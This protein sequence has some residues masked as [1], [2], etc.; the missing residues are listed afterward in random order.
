MNGMTKVAVLLV[1]LVA[2]VSFSQ[3]S[4]PKES[5]QQKENSVV[6]DAVTVRRIMSDSVAIEAL[7][8]SQT[9]YSLS[10]YGLMGTV[11]I[12]VAVFVFL[13][14]R[15]VKM[16]DK[17]LKIENKIKEIL[18]NNRKDIQSD[19]KGEFKTARD[20]IKEEIK[21]A[22]DGI[23]NDFETALANSKGELIKVLADSKEK[24]ETALARCGKNQEPDVE[25]DEQKG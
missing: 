18:A 9:F 4:L 6:Y 25:S 8:S 1:S 7:K 2:V 19:V 3:E 15:F 16:L 11:L 5:V 12:V 21:T 22:L 17:R 20:G 24:I 10:F 23:K 13:N 14:M